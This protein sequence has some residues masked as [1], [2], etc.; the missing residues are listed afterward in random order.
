M[1]IIIIMINI[2]TMIIFV[3]LIVF[4]N[5]RPRTTKEA[6]E[7][8]RGYPRQGAPKSAQEPPN[9]YRWKS[10][11]ASKS[12]QKP[13]KHPKAAK[14][15]PTSIAGKRP[16]APKSSHEPSNKSTCET[17]KYPTAENRVNTATTPLG[18]PTAKLRKSV[19]NCYPTPSDAWVAYHTYVTWKR[20]HTVTQAASLVIA[21]GVHERRE[22]R[23]PSARILSRKA[24]MTMLMRTPLRGFKKFRGNS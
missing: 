12:C 4:R 19:K 7:S 3:A 8:P 14:S 23:Y 20:T 18:I 15:L 9:T 21:V 5:G 10:L 6:Q 16:K 13:K 1:I 22:C 2:V 17:Y 11:E 24:L